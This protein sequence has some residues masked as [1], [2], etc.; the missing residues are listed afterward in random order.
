MVK[1]YA[2]QGKDLSIMHLF[3]DLKFISGS[4]RNINYVKDIMEN[5]FIP[6]WHEVENC[7]NISRE[8]AC[9]YKHPTCLFKPVK[10]GHTILRRKPC[11]EWCDSFHPECGATFK[12]LVA[13]HKL[14]SYCQRLSLIR[15]LERIPE[16]KEFPVRDIQKIEQCKLMDRSGK[17]CNLDTIL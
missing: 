1:Q 9:H 10:N 17:T 11:K 12:T 6:S 2:T 5:I 13:I 7:F 4:C 16:C 14:N 8:I 3:R 15:R